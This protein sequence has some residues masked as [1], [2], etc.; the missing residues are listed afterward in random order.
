MTAYDD[1]RADACKRLRDVLVRRRPGEDLV[2]RT[3]CRV[4]E[5]NGAEGPDIELHRH[6]PARDE[7]SSSSDSRSRHQAELA[8]AASRTSRSQFPATNSA[9][10]REKRGNALRLERAPENIASDDDPVDVLGSDL[11]QDRVERGQVPMDVVQRSD[12]HEAG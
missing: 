8:S 3:G 2:G 10:W 7:A 6:R 5:G 11:C 1:V 12:S 4:A 9:S